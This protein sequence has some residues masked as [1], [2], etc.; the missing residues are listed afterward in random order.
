M[1]SQKTQEG[2]ATQL[3]VARMEGRELRTKVHSLQLQLKRRRLADDS[4]EAASNDLA[5][6]KVLTSL[7]A[8]RHRQ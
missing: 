7:N 4:T 5:L 8:N 6:N 3:E 1:K 2:L